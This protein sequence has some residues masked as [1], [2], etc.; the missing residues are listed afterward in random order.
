MSTVHGSVEPI[1]TDSPVNA[2][3]YYHFRHNTWWRQDFPLYFRFG[4][5]RRPHSPR[6]KH[7]LVLPFDGFR[8][9]CESTIY[10]NDRNA[11]LTTLRIDG[12]NQRQQVRP[13]FVLILNR[14]F[15]CHHGC[16][17]TRDRHKHCYFRCT[18]VIA[19]TARVLTNKLLICGQP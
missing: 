18:I 12:D 17:T 15:R 5:S 1:H 6:G 19:D 14:L 3:I 7:I 13:L 10:C 16:F 9:P 2:N 11:V 4:A 8:R